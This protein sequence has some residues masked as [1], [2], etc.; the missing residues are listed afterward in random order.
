[1]RASSTTTALLLLSLSPFCAPPVAGAD[2]R[3]GAGAD[4]LHGQYPI[5]ARVW[6]EDQRDY[7]TRGDRPRIRF[8]TSADAFVAVLHIDADGRLDFLYP[9]SPMDDEY[10]EAGQVHSLPYRS[11]G[12]GQTAI[13]SGQGIGYLYIV[14]SPRPLDYGLFRRR[15][16]YGWDWSYAGQFVRGDPFWA[17]EQITRYLVPDWG[18]LPIS[19]DYFSYHVGGRHRYPSYAC[20]SLHRSSAG[21]WGWGWGSGYMPS[22]YGACDRVDY[23][24]RD[25]PYYFDA[26]RYRGDRR[27]HFREYGRDP[28]HRF[29]EDPERRSSGWQSDDRYGAPARGRVAPS[30]GSYGGEAAPRAEEPVEPSR[31]PTLERRDPERQPARGVA[32]PS[33]GD[34]PD[35]RASPPARGESGGGSGGGTETTRAGRRR[36]GGD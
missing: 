7:Y 6:V 5:R 19:V 32:R 9:A 27:S 14:A 2:D 26:V 4:Q 33:S 31:R 20:T 16:G 21:G 10:A 28:R 13:G 3:A 23:F 11:G 17:F 30:G 1:M 18:F 24:L 8:T 29:K 25:N 34:A 22:Y 36:P 12:V 35:R 15:G